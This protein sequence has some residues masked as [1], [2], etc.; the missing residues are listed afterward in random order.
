MKW[1][2]DLI[3]RV[4]SKILKPCQTCDRYYVIRAGTVVVNHDIG[5]TE[6]GIC[7]ECQAVFKA[8]SENIGTSTNGGSNPVHIHQRDQQNKGRFAD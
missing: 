1:L 3:L 8:A 7:R 4:K 6:Y 2:T 5:T